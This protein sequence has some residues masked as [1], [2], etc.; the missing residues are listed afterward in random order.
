MKPRYAAVLAANV[1]VL[2]ILIYIFYVLRARYYLVI[3]LPQKTVVQLGPFSTQYSCENARRGL[4]DMTVGGRLDEKERGEIL[5][6]M[7]CVPSR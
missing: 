7:A 6:F 1:L 5:K 3:V 4:P 2:I